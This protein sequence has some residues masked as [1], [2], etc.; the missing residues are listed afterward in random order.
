MPD[1]RVATV[2]CGLPVDMLAPQRAGDSNA[3][4]GTPAKAE[5]ARSA[6]RRLVLAGRRPAPAVRRQLVAGACLHPRRLTIA[7]DLLLPEGRLGLEIVHQ[8]FGGLEGSL[9]MRRRGQHQHNVV[10]R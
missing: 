4:D 8:E 1:M 10:S 2:L 9:P 6:V 7:G 3:P 5:L